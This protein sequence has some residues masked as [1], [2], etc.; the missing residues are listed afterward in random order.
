MGD[1]GSY[2]VGF[3]LAMSTVLATLAGANRPGHAILVPL[4]LMA[5]PIYDTV[6]VVLI[7]LRAGGS[8]FAADRNHISHRLVE[9]GLTPPQAVLVIYVATAICG[10]AAII[11][12]RLKLAGAV[13][14]LLGIVGLLGLTAMLELRVR[15]KRSM[16]E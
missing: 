1:A 16:H 6:S 13:A 7:R 11:L 9:L 3:L 4:C 2:F 8:P 14:I 5:V 10:V 12:S 15:R